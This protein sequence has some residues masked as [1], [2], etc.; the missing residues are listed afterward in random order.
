MAAGTRWRLDPLDREGRFRVDAAVVRVDAALDPARQRWRQLAGLLHRVRLQH[1]PDGLLPVHDLVLLDAR[2]RRYYASGHDPQLRLRAPLARG[3]YMLELALDLPGA[4]AQA[5]IYLDHGQG[6]SEAS[7][8]GLPLRSGQ[9]GKRLLY[10]GGPARLRLDPMTVRGVFGLRHFR[11]AR[12]TES[13]ACT[14]MRRKLEAARTRRGAVPAD[15]PAPRLDTPQALWSHYARLFER[16]E[17]QG[18][19]YAGWIEEVEQP[20]LASAAAQAAEAAGWSFRPVF[21]V[22]VPVHET[23][24]PWLRDCLASVRR[25]TY[26]HWELCV[27]DDASAAPHVAA[28]LDEAA[29][30]RRVRIVRRTERGHVCAASNSALAL[31]RGDFVVLLDH[32]DLLAPHAL[33]ALARALQSRPGALIVYSDEDKLDES[34]DRCDP[35]FKPAWSPDLLGSQN[36]VSHLGAYRRT[37]VEQVGGFRPGFE[38]SQD[39]DLLLRCASR[40]ADPR[41]VLH[42]PQVLYH[43]R[44]SP[45]STAS[46]HAAKDYAS[47]A[48]RRALQAHFGARAPGAQVDIIG[49]G[50]YRVRWPLPDPPPLVSLIVPTRDGLDVL[51]KCIESI[52]ERTTYPTYEILVVDNQSSDPAALAYLDE[53]PARSGGRVRVLRHDAPFNFSAIN[54]AAAAQARGSVLGLI[55]NDI[56][57]ISPGWLDEMVGQALRPEIGCVGAKLYYP[58]DTVQH[59]GVVLGIGGV[60][61]HAH[62]HFP[63]DAEGYFSRLQVVHNV[64]AV[65][66]A[67][68]VVR[69]SVF[70]EVGGLDAEHLVV[71]FNDVDLCL[72]VQ[73]AGYRNLWTPFAEL[74]HHESR[75]RGADVRPEAA[76][77]HDREARVMVARWGARLKADPYYSPNLTLEREDFSLGDAHPAHRVDARSAPPSR[78]AAAGVPNDGPE[79]R[80]PA[81]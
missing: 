26:P 59:G 58:D 40:V 63:R 7:S 64:S 28:V 38:G 25:Q 57:V 36:Y 24:E 13:F 6:D 51:R 19:D 65:T 49:P 48:A 81:P 56:E 60:A 75:T 23:P 68:L 54:N 9:V 61:G 41:D 34:G 4:R 37:L 12:V 76:A 32:D 66:G 44:K 1:G 69:K 27:A 53:L 30:D 47:A 74:Y 11:L 70:D 79:A 16:A 52:V 35:Y 3:W 80:T 18:I 39:Y 14:R 45:G 20:A 17:T 46:S 72:K 77:R 22:V 43:W 42:V 55:N 31:A 29:A 71:A 78:A 67:A 8:L 15:P 10:L 33:H 21:S 50:R 62:K 73:A 2:R 5:R